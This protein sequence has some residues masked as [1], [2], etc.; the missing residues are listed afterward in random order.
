MG[1]KQTQGV[2]N[3][4]EGRRLRAWELRE[5]GWKQQRIAEALGVTPGAVS[6]WMARGRA[7]GVRGLRHQPPPGRE[8]RLSPQQLRQLPELLAKGAEHFG[9]RGEVWT[10]ARVGEVIRRAFGVSYHP[11]QVGRILKAIHWT[12][13]KPRRRASQRDEAAIQRWREQ[14][15][16][17]IKKRPAPKGER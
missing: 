12:R 14:K 10:R 6:Q 8:A 1:R 17:E 7:G 13:Q 4:R 9:F 5:Q 3:W 16:G 11:T 2:Q 15:W